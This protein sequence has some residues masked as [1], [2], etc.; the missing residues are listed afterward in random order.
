M[1]STAQI[2][3]H[4]VKQMRSHITNQCIDDVML[5]TYD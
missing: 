5:R 3:L 4:Y 1:H 2:L